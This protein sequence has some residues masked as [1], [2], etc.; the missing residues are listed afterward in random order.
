MMASSE[1]VKQYEK[2]M[3]E[4]FD[5]EDLLAQNFREIKK[6]RNT[7]VQLGKKLGAIELELRG[8]FSRIKV[9]RQEVKTK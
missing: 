1:F 7:R 2:L 8:L 5:T 6:L 4:K 9:T 3:G